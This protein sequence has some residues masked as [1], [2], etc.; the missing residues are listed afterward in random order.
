[1][2]TDRIK[3]KTITSSSMYDSSSHRGFCLTMCEDGHWTQQS[4]DRFLTDT[5]IGLIEAVILS[6][7]KGFLSVAEE[8]NAT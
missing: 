8:R 7:A 3:N 5:Q 4:A 6:M 1:M 2:I